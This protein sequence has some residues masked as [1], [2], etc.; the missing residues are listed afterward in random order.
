MKPKG[1][2]SIDKQQEWLV[3][4]KDEIESLKANKTWV[5]VPGPSSYN[6]VDFHWVLRSK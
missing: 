5:L 2:K 6:F 1:F 3:A 4:M